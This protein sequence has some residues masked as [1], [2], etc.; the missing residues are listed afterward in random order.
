M[1]NHGQS[2]YEYRVKR[3]VEAQINEQCHKK[4]PELYADRKTLWDAFAEVRSMFRTNTHTITRRADT[5]PQGMSNCERQFAKS[6]ANTISGT[7][8][9]GS[10]LMHLM[11]CCQ[12]LRK[13]RETVTKMDRFFDFAR[14]Q[15][16]IFLLVCF[17][18]EMLRN[19]VFFGDFGFIKHHPPSMFICGFFFGGLMMALLIIF[20]IRVPHP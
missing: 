6:S 17:V 9:S 3:A 10:A 16:I 18:L 7:E 11:H 14:E 20:K 8:M 19:R 15:G 13:H 12:V 1:S 5:M 2:N 4:N